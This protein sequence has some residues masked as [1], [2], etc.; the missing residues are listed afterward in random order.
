LPVSV[1]W[2]GAHPAVGLRVLQRRDDIHPSDIDQRID[3]P[4]ARAGSDLDEVGYG[5]LGGD[6][7]LDE[8]GG[9]AARA[10]ERRDR[11]ARL[12]VAVRQLRQAQRC[13]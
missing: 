13:R 9:V 3:F 6:V 10:E 11:L 1:G 2:V 8:G 7:R 4:A 5:G 12:R